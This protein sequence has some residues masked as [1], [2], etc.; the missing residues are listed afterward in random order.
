[1]LSDLREDVSRAYKNHLET[2]MLTLTSQ[3]TNT[4]FFPLHA[5]THTNPALIFLQN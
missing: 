5:H 2:K 4:F 3:Q 1:M